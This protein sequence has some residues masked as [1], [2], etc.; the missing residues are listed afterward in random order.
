MLK[1]HQNF[2]YISNQR[3][4]KVR[5]M[6]FNVTFNTSPVISWRTVLFG[7]GL[8]VTC[9]RSVVFSGYYGFLNQ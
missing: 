4:Q 3:L 7:G 9:S 2:G 8:S 5:D 6:V 1:K